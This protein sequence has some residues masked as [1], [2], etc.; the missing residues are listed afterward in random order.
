MTE[1][2]SQKPESGESF[3]EGKL[4][5]AMPGMPDP[6]FEKS[7]IFMCAHSAKGAMGLIINKPIDG[8]SFRELM[9][10]F[11][12]DVTADRANTPILFGG[13]VHL[14]RGF[15]LHSADYGSNEATLAITSEISLTATTDILEA[16]SHGCGPSKSML[17][18]GYAGWG[19]GQIE[20][21]ILANGWIH[22]DADPGLVFDTD[23]DLKWQKAIARLG[24]DISGLSA[25]AGRA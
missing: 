1:A 21:E 3:L 7:V 9:T 6:R 23:H 5:I 18:L 22:C 19:I 16:I 12:I 4:L 2:K 17:A 11:S 8:L 14:G 24:A 20:S 25:D 13:P 15:V 10:R